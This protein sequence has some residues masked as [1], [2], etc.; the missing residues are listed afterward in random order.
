MVFRGSGVIMPCALAGTWDAA[1]QQPTAPIE[2]SARI[3]LPA[4]IDSVML[5]AGCLAGW[6][7]GWLAGWLAGGWLAG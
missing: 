4:I 1:M 5:A 2:T 6:L 3:Q 7:V